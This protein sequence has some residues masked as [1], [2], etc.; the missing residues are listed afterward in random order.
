MKIWSSDFGAN[1][2]ARSTR[3]QKVSPFGNVLQP[4]GFYDPIVVVIW[5]VRKFVVWLFWWCVFLLVSI[6]YILPPITKRSHW[7]PFTRIAVEKGPK[8]HNLKIRISGFWANGVARSTRNQKLSPFGNVFQ[9]IA[10]YDPI[11]G[12]IWKVRKFVSLIILMICVPINIY[13]KTSA[14]E[15]NCAVGDRPRAAIFCV[16]CHEEAAPAQLGRPE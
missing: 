8:R 4:V 14:W 12:V 1:G 6:F 3:N 10:L 5:E 16:S 15:L 7:L 2:V 13:F 11:F 9:P